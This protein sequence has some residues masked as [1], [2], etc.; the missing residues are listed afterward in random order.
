MKNNKNSFDK[1][2]AKI[3]TA[4]YGHPEKDLKLICV[5]GVTG[6]AVVARY[7][8]EILKANNL[9]AAVLASDGD[10][11]ASVLRKFLGDAWRSGVNYVVITVSPNMLQHSVLYGLPV[12]VAVLT[13]ND[14]K[15]IKST[16]IL[17]KMNPDLVILNRDD[18]Y[19][20]DFEN[21]TGKKDTITYGRDRSALVKIDNSKLYKM[22]S[23]ANLIIGTKNFT[24]ATFV[25]GEE[26]ISYMACAAAVSMALRIDSD[27]IIEGVSNYLPE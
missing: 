10:I 20:R 14:E 15:S 25:P 16:S 2:K 5:T 27:V 23:E 9:K 21:F 22:G 18:Q 7:I 8:H 11:K 19:Y 12:Y 3:L 4:Y 13:D 24:V 17:F 6:R 1:I 26:A